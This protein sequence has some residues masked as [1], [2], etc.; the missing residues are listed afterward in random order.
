VHFYIVS[1]WSANCSDGSCTSFIPDGDRGPNYGYSSD[2]SWKSIVDLLESHSPAINWR[3]YVM[4]NFD[5]NCGSCNGPCLS[6][7]QDSYFNIWDPL[8][9]FASIKGTPREDKVKNGQKSG[10]PTEGLTEFWHDVDIGTLPPVSWVIPG[11]NESEHAFGNPPNIKVTDG[12]TYVTT[13]INKIMSKPD[14]WQHCAIFVAWDD[15]GGFYDHVKPPV[16]PVPDNNGYG[17]R[18]PAMLISPFAKEGYVDHQE[19]SFDAYLKLIEDRFLE[20]ARI[21]GDGRAKD[22]MGSIREEAANL[23]DL[24]YEF[25]FTQPARAPMPI[26]PVK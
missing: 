9:W 14:I 3:Y 13:L 1:G 24:L 4:T 6:S 5:V 10:V 17:L 22:G 8:P 7:G 21:M 26:C 25:D 20:S 23:G 11:I 2:F 16:P 12:Q 15:W 19:L 18:V